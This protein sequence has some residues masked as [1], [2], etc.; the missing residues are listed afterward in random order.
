MD[1]IAVV[2][3][4]MGRGI[5]EGSASSAQVCAPDDDKENLQVAD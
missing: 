1:V 4:V 5:G 2:G 3:D